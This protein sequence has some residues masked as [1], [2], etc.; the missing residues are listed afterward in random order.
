[1]DIG[2]YEELTNDVGWEM[3]TSPAH[4]NF[5]SW[6]SMVAVLHNEAD[7]KNLT[8]QMGY[9]ENKPFAL[10][11]P[12]L[13]ESDRVQLQP[14]T[15]VY[16]PLSIFLLMAAWKR[17]P[18]WVT[19]RAVRNWKLSLYLYCLYSPYPPL[20]SI[21]TFSDA[22]DSV[23]LQGEWPLLE[24][25]AMTIEEIHYLCWRDRHNARVEREELPIY[26]KLLGDLRG[27]VRN[28]V[29]GGEAAEMNFTKEKVGGLEVM[30]MPYGGMLMIEALLS[31]GGMV[32][33][34]L[35]NPVRLGL[36]VKVKKRSLSGS[37][38][39]GGQDW[40]EIERAD[41]ADT[42]QRYV[43]KSKIYLKNL[44]TDEIIEGLGGDTAT[45]IRNDKL[46]SPILLYSFEWLVAT[47][48]SM[49][50]YLPLQLFCLEDMKSP[51]GFMNWDMLPF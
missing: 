45:Q 23:Y 34:K 13:Y 3:I 6:D 1:M 9:G 12:Y 18:E 37:R 47:G 26:T 10:Q 8:Y 22:L 20:T 40:I 44:D 43:L 42:D 39:W 35:D 28:N 36:V 51:Q 17:T 49:V 41:Y 11:N 48:M 38:D 50:N 30:I 14:N 21:M 19:R 5:L 25:H 27:A 29:Y 33:N 31:K 15:F 46:V 7:S 24:P 32:I 4:L 2:F 16:P